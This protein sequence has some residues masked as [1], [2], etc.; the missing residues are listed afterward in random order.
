MRMRQRREYIQQ[1]AYA[2][3]DAEGMSSAVHIDRFSLHIVQHQVRPV[4]LR[5]PG[6]DQP[7]NVRVCQARE[8]AAFALE[9]IERG[10]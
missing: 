9:A 6:I 4:A 1:Q 7:R 10:G 5:D 3:F 8:E 2:L